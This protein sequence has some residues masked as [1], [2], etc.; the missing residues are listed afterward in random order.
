[1]LM[2]LLR[3]MA[4][5]R[6]MTIILVGHVAKGEVT[7]E[8]PTMR[9]SGAWMANSRAAYALWTPDRKTASELAAKTGAPPEHLV[10]GMLQK[11]NH[12]GAPIGKRRLFQRDATCGRLIDITHREH[13]AAPVS[14]DALLTALVAACA[15]AAAAG[16]PF[17]EH[18]IGGLYDQRDDLPPM[19]SG[20]S[21]GKLA[22]L[23][24]AAKQA[25]RLVMGRIT[26]AG[27]MKYLDVPDGTLA[28]GHTLHVPTGSRR[29]AIARLRAVPLSHIV[30]DGAK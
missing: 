3:D 17:A 18:K 23:S 24:G 27:A 5:R 15:E 25:N 12:A 4:A 10:F 6:H 22:E 26:P 21:K 30:P 11:A 29:E 9:G 20:L 19:L 7:P 1:V 28:R 13:P 14:D 8:G 16:M 2:R